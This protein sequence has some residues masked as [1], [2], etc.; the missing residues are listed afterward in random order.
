MK[1]QIT[2]DECDGEGKTRSELC[3]SK[4]A[5]HNL[6]LK[7]GT[8]LFD[9][10]ISEFPNYL[11]P[12]T[13]NFVIERKLFPV[14]RQII[15]QPVTPFPDCISTE[16][17]DSAIRDHFK[18]F[19]SPIPFHLNHQLIITFDC[20]DDLKFAAVF[21][22]TKVVPELIEQQF[23]LDD[24]DS[25]V[26]LKLKF[27][28]EKLPIGLQQSLSRPFVFPRG[29]LFKA[30][31]ESEALKNF[32]SKS[33]GKNVIS[34]ALIQGPNRSGKRTLIRRLADDLGISLFILDFYNEAEVPE[35]TQKLTQLLLN[36]F[37]DHDN[38]F[39][40]GFELLN[41][42]LKFRSIWS[43]ISHENPK[44]NLKL[45]CCNSFLNSR[46]ISDYISG[47]FD[48]IENI[49]MV[50]REGNKKLVKEFFELVPE[51]VYLIN[52]KDFIGYSISDFSDLFD[53][54]IDSNFKNDLNLIFDDFKGK[55]KLRRS[56][57]LNTLEIPKVTWDQVAG[58]DEVKIILQGLIEKLSRKPRPT[59]IL[60]HGPP[61]TGKTLIAKALA[62]QSQFALLPVKGPELLSPYIGES[63][64]ALRTIFREA[65]AMSPCIIF[66]D[67]LD[68]LVPR[69][70]EIGDSV[71]V[72]DRMVATFMT[73]MDQINE[74][75][76]EKG[77]DDSI[78]FVI[79]ATNRPDL[80]DSALL[81]QG[82]FDS[83]ILLDSPKTIEQ[84]AAILK[85]SC[86]NLNL[87]DG[88]DFK[89][90]FENIREE[91]NG[92]DDFRSNGK[93][94]EN[95]GKEKVLSPAQ[96]ASIAT[97]ASRKALEKKLKGI[98]VND[99]INNQINNETLLIDPITTD[100]LKR[101]AEELFNK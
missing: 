35:N 96:I 58:L 7:K 13:S 15:L 44:R 61:G 12:K 70:G 43:K 94:K 34:T 53:K 67:E 29:H 8:T 21:S 38:V 3:L 31:P 99:Q 60:L 28:N 5:L 80:I 62:T 45:I 6:K 82:R 79:G 19:K 71:G 101:S 84:K 41:E 69:R 57:Q 36:I 52:E 68:A 24:N 30:F 63:E 72:A 92:Y 32:L 100:D 1:C 77:E 83:S 33:F 85:A 18:A 39:I 76:D 40:I 14:A 86:L 4:L 47:S 2:F 17:I 10:K 23:I 56:L 75:I 46:S 49:K 90:P 78:V 59:G 27:I 93:E 48:V 42:D 9:S 64:S 25:E 73:E 16:Q 26:F 20:I 87:A 22:I 37:N 66:F 98:I 55:I 11:K 95:N 51:A 97:N 81:R 50:T 89:I 91:G 88:I 65:K 54:L 74:E